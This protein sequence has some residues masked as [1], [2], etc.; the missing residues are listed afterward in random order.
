M[1]VRQPVLAALMVLATARILLSGP[2]PLSA[3]TVT[4]PHDAPTIQAGIDAVES[5]DTVLVRD[6][7]YSGYGNDQLNF[8]GKDLSLV[9][10]YGPDYTIID[11]SSG[12]DRA[13]YFCSG[14][15]RQARVQGFT[16]RWFDNASND[17]SAVYCSHAS[18]TFVWVRFED[19]GGPPEDSVIWSGGAVYSANDAAP[20]FVNCTFSRCSWLFGGA[21]G[22]EGAGASIEYCRFEDCEARNGGALC[23]GSDASA[24]VT[25][26]EFVSCRAVVPWPDPYSAYGGGIAASGR[27]VVQ[28]SVFDHCQAYGDN[29]AGGGIT[30]SGTCE[31]RRVL[32]VDCTAA[33][34]SAVRCSG[35]AWLQRITAVDNGG[36][37]GTVCAMG[38]LDLS[39][40]IIAGN[41]SPGVLNDGGAVTVSCCDVWDNAGGDYAGDLED[42]TGIS[43]NISVDPWFC[44]AVAGDYTLASASPCLP[45]NNDCG[46]L[47]GAYGEGCAGATDAPAAGAPPA[48]VL[49]PNHPNPFNPATEI[50]FALPTAM[51]VTLTIHDVSGRR[52]ATL[53]A[54]EPLAAGEHAVAWRG[55]DDAGRPLPS[56]ICFS[57]LEA[58]GTRAARKMTLLK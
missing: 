12:Y 24:F 6:G 23:V 52:L 37:E 43:G 18:P 1:R 15:T 17:G 25:E 34:G 55:R 21:I 48:V 27:L 40:S 2:L 38:D 42:Q 51:A 32:F 36:G 33:V 46:L 57:V 31:L 26:S 49:A 39:Q 56:G 50:R 58:G 5:G 16:I 19:C 30:A 9:G 35:D 22:V 3:A 54:G 4:V 29:G 7:V 14:E 53:L 44:G 11:G 10:E 41:D 45:E 20:R 28:E 8:H 47:M 13:F